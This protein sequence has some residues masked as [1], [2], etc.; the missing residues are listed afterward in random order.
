MLPRDAYLI[1]Y[2]P[3]IALIN[4]SYLIRTEHSN[5]EECTV[6]T[7]YTS[8]GIWS[9]VSSTLYGVH[10]SVQDQS[11]CTVYNRQHTV[12]DVHCTIDSS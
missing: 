9:S 10:R 5:C 3:C 1:F 2:E 4:A 11:Q 12:H 6:Y 8:Q 7:V